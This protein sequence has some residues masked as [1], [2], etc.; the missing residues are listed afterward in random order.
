MYSGPITD[1]EGNV[2]GFVDSV[3]PQLRFVC[4]GFIDE[5]IKGEMNSYECFN[6][7]HGMI[8]QSQKEDEEAEKAYRKTGKRQFIV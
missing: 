2:T 5:A 1:E 6:I 8:L 3:D 7:I 4:T